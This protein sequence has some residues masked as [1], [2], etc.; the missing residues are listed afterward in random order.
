MKIEFGCGDKVKKG[1]VGCDVRPNPAIKYVCN[2]WEIDQYVEKDSVD[3]IFSRHMFE[4]LTFNQGKLALNSWYKILKSGGKIQL[5]TPNLEYHAK[6]YLKFRNNKTQITP[7][8]RHQKVSEFNHAIGSI[9]GW[10]RDYEGGEFFVTNQMWDIHKSG[11]DF[12]M[13]SELINKT[14]FKNIERQKILPEHHLDI[15]FSK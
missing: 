5:I 15:I 10:Q 8:I 2:C 4:H 3:E 7:H 13:L 1:F 11:Y 6:Q 12:E 14:G 9:F